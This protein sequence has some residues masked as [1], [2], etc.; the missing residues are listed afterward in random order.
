ME[1]RWDHLAPAREDSCPE[2][3]RE[4]LRSAE[5]D[6]PAHTSEVS[7]GSIGSPVF[8]MGSTGLPVSGLGELTAHLVPAPESP[9]D[10]SP[11]GPSPGPDSGAG[12]GAGA[13]IGKEPCE[14]GDR[15]PPASDENGDR[16]SQ[17]AERVARISSGSQ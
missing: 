2:K 15:L 12:I 13:E 5:E 9:G 10:H 1:G 3:A 17:A 7:G 16:G 11:T 6:E 4:S 14:D 8:S